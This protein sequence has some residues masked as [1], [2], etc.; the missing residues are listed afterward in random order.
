MQIINKNSNKVFEGK[1]SEGKTLKINVEFISIIQ[2]W[3]H[4]LL[5]LSRYNKRTYM[6]LFIQ[7]NVSYRL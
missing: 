4:N 1:N 6:L 7:I 2:I 5:I 3:G